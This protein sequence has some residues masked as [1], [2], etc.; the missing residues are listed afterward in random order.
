MSECKV[1]FNENYCQSCSEY[2]S[3][4]YSSC[5]G[6]EYDRAPEYYDRQKYLADMAEMGLIEPDF[7]EVLSDGELPF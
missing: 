1:D 4:Y 5:A 7:A 2:N 3:C 6:I